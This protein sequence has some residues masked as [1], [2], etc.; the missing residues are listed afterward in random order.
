MTTNVRMIPRP[1]GASREVRAGRLQWRASLLSSASDKLRGARARCPYRA[2]TQRTRWLSPVQVCRVMV[3]PV[4]A[5]RP[6]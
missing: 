2:M 4:G 5:M 3:S 6:S 1:R